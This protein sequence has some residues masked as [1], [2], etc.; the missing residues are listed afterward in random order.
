MKKLRWGFL[1]TAR[2]GQKNW[3]AIR[4]AE[5]CVV[6]AVASREKARSEKFIASCQAAAPL[7]TPPVAL[8][9]YEELIASP[10]VDAVYIP[11]PT[12]LRANWVIRA[13]EAGK[14]VLCEKPCAVSAAELKGIL[15]ACRRNR[16]QFLDGVKFMHHPR[17]NRVREVLNEG[18]SVGE[19]RRITSSF[20]FAAYDKFFEENIRVRHDL[21]PAGSLGD[22]GWYCI[23]FSLW[24]MGWQMPLEVSGRI[25][26]DSRFRRDAPAVPVEF[27]GEL[28]FA[29]GAS[30]ALYSSF[31]SPNQQWVNIS[32]N[33]GW[34]RMD[35]FVLPADPHQAHLQVNGVEALVRNCDCV[36]AH[37]AS[38][39]GSQQVN[40]FRNFANQVFT[41]KINEDWPEWAWK[42]QVV[43]DA[44]LESAHRPT[45]SVRL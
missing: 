4:E 38:Q 19:I 37:S 28:M 30:A 8:G 16:V 40:M 29:G 13:A 27:S 33:K 32:G 36:G 34:L 26:S 17:M 25:L 44:C 5:N 41:G 20:T 11:L 43:M 9:S 24:A 10:I 21:E 3:A 12:A 6:T 14:H 31:I 35:D 39:A 15:E 1:S 42:T 7:E 23:R 45:S 2:I 18:G 22:L